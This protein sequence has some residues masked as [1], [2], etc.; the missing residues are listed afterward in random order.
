VYPV[1]ETLEASGRIRRG[2]FISGMG[3]AQFALPGAV[4]LLRSERRPPSGPGGA[5]RV[6]ILAA[7]DPANPYGVTVPWPVKGP[8]RVPGAYVLL[9][10]GIGSA[11]LERGG[12]GM[13]ALRAF[14][15][16]WEEATG[17]ALARLV[18]DGRWRRLVLQRY[19]EE[20]AP[21]LQA[22]GFTPSP[23]GLIRYA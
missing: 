7:T 17:A 11:Y 12:K 21:M 20:M 3:G 14:D 22:A 2:Y 6:H 10:D 9:V 18:A 4:E 5:G 15:G 23:K 13:M 1:L 19:P 8:S 16:S